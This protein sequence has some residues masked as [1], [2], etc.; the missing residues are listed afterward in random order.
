[1]TTTTFLATAWDFEWSIN[2]GCVFL[3]TI[4]FW[5]VRAGIWR[6]I[7]FVLGVLLLFLALQ[8]PLDALG[9]TYLFSA[10]MAQHLL[11][12]LIVP[13]L[14][15]LGIGE[16]E[17]R[18]WLRLSYIAKTERILG[19]PYVAW[20]AGVST[21]TLWHVPLFYNFALAHEDVHILQHLTFLVTATMFW[22]PVL[23]PL[24]ER[25]LNTG[26]A[27]AYLFAAAAENSIL[28]IIL[29]FMPVGYYP[30]YVHPVDEYGALSLIRN[31]WGISAVSDQRL[32]G[33]LMWVPGCSVYFMAILALIAHWYAQPETEPELGLLVGA[34]ER[35][36]Q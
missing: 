2:L 21:M 28:G 8:S 30:A 15:I 1:M 20:F 6:R 12:I 3:L 25:R 7:S 4:Y 13:P 18:A 32:G 24:P 27:V 14:L 29:T 23:H 5:K 35:G 19:N 16:R 26:A 17:V 34:A 31:G 33:L 9:D 36:T 22:W 10:H 11:L